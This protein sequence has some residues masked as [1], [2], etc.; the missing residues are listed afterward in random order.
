MVSNIIDGIFGNTNRINPESLSLEAK[1]YLKKIREDIK[2]RNSIDKVMSSIAAET[3]LQYFQEYGES[4]LA[5]LPELTTVSYYVIG[6]FRQ[7][8]AQVSFYFILG[9]THGLLL[10][11]TDQQ[12]LADC[13][14]QLMVAVFT[15]PIFEFTVDERDT[16]IG[17]VHQVRTYLGTV[18]GYSGRYGTLLP[19]ALSALL[20]GMKNG[21]EICNAPIDEIQSC[22]VEKTYTAD[23]W[24]GR[25][26]FYTNLCWPIWNI[27]AMGFVRWVKRTT[28]I[29]LWPVEY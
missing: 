8:I 12:E 4:P 2:N 17:M 21:L 14:D 11:C 23:R 20:E 22:V 27:T 13:I 29:E 7:Y 1:T 5:L 25:F 26:R 15:N 19:T 6:G 16:V 3:L 18:Q 24:L 28:G 10:I 9:V